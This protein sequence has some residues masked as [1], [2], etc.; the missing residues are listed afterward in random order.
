MCWSIRG[1]GRHTAEFIQQLELRGSGQEFG[2]Q[3]VERVDEVEGGIAGYQLALN[4]EVDGTAGPLS[5]SP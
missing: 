1:L 4:I 2:L 3:A 5:L